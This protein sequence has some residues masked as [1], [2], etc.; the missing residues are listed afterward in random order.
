[1]EDKISLD[2]LEEELREIETKF[3]STISSA[4]EMIKKNPE[5]EKE[6]LNTFVV[7]TM[8]IYEFFMRETERTGMEQVGK[9]VF[10]YAM[11]KKI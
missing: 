4:L 5:M 7:P 10:K 8:R 6:V 9:N 3:K 1:M 11:F 2:M